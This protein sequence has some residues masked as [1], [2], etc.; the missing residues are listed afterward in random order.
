MSLA[1]RQEGTFERLCAIKTLITPHRDDP[2]VRDMFL[3][4]AR[5]AGMIRHPNVVGVVD[6][7]S[8]VEGP[9][10]VMEYV[11]GV[12]AHRLIAQSSARDA[13]IPL[14]VAL[15]IVMQAAEGLHAAHE[16]KALD[17]KPLDIVHRDVSPQNIL[18]GVDGA[19]RVADFGIA[20][21]MGRLSRTSTGILK[22]KLGY[23]SPEQLQFEEPDRRSDIFSLGVVL[24]ELLSGQRLYANTNG[25]DGARRILREPPPDLADYREDAPDALVALLF[26]MLAKK[27]ELRPATARQVARVLGEVQRELLELEEPVS[28]GEYVASSFGPELEATRERIARAMTRASSI[29]PRPLSIPDIEAA[30]V[31]ALEVRSTAPDP[32]P[33]SR[34]KLVA[35]A[36]FGLAAVAGVGVVM[37]TQ[38]DAQTTQPPPQAAAPTPSESASP[39]RVAVE[40]TNPAE[41]PADAGKAPEPE[42]P[43]RAAA[44]RTGA[45]AKPPPSR[46]KPAAAPQPKPKAGSVPLWEWQ[47]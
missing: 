32:P 22:G 27:P 30:T 43:P 35:G 24:F 10:L 45:R 6:V 46:P 26:S 29:P 37:S 13:P 14:N 15:E 41:A 1:L 21:A 36:A 17:G 34:W 28:V 2:E 11:E 9:F 38:N 44:P 40:A 5:I 18:V 42:P 20:K 31:T 8:S 47:N 7:G 39:V 23:I 3:D 4:E 25:T 16:L 12:A 33:F 19:A